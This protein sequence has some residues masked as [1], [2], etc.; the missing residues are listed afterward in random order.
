MPEDQKCLTVKNWLHRDS[1]PSYINLCEAPT[2]EGRDC[3]ARLQ[4]M[5][6][7]EKMGI[8][9]A[10]KLKIQKPLPSWEL[11]EMQLQYILNRVVCST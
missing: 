4:V 5:N 2:V 8:R 3:Y 9:Y 6:G 10:L 1:L 11:L 7:H